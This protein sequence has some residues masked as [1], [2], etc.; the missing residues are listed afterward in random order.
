MRRTLFRARRIQTLDYLVDVHQLTLK[1]GRSALPSRRYE[2]TLA[3]NDFPNTRSVWN[4]RMA[5][6]SA[7]W[8]ANAVIYTVLCNGCLRNFD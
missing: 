2:A 4:D 1:T 3:T 8:R 6:A 5:L 7:T